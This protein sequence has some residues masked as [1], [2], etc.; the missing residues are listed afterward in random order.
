M[1]LW[2]LAAFLC[3]LAAAGTAVAVASARMMGF[4][5]LVWANAALLWLW[6]GAAVHHARKGAPSCIGCGAWDA[7]RLPDGSCARCGLRLPRAAA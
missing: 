7:G 3:L 1:D 4:D 5:L 6:F 2:R